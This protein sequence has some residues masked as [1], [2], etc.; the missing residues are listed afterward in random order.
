MD[1]TSRLCQLDRLD[2][3]SKESHRAP[4]LQYMGIKVLGWA[5]TSYMSSEAFA[6]DKLL[7]WLSCT[8]S[9]MQQQMPHLIPEISIFHSRLGW[10]LSWRGQ[11]PWLR[12]GGARSRLC[13]PL[14]LQGRAPCQR[15]GGVHSRPRRPWP[16]LGQVPW[17]R[18]GDVRIQLWW[19]WSWLVRV[20]WLRAGGVRSRPV[21]ALV[22]GGG[23]RQSMRAG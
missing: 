14:S 9:E 21:V 23:K 7:G 22:T 8:C 20:P 12:A 5:V 10:P 1:E 15:A 19:P 18:A 4:S 11:A 3:H 13:L 17:L 6:R 2:L 16:F